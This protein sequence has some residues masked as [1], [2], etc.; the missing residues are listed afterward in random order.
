MLTVCCLVGVCYL[1]FVV[2]CSVFVVCCVLS[3]VCCVLCVVFC[4]LCVVCVD[5]IRCRVCVC[6]FAC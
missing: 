6:L 4:V 2:R 3:V 1:F 5:V